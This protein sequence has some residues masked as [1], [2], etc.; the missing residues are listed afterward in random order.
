[1]SS[2]L[3]A[4]KRHAQFFYIAVSN[5]GRSYNNSPWSITDLEKLDL[6]WE[7]IE[8]AF[9]FLESQI[10]IH[11]DLAQLCNNY[12]SISGSYLLI[13]KHP[14][15][16]LNWLR[17]GLVAS[18]IIKRR[19]AENS[20]LGNIGNCYYYLGDFDNAM[21]NYEK[22]LQGYKEMQDTLGEART[23]SGIGTI[24]A[25]GG[26]FVRAIQYFEQSSFV[27]EKAGDGNLLAKSLL[28]IGGAHVDEGNPQS[29]LPILKRALELFVSQ[30]DAHGKIQ[31][32]NNIATANILLGDYHNA[33]EHLIVG[34]QEAN[35]L[36]A[37]LETAHLFGTLGVVFGKL[38][39]YEKAIAI[40]KESLNI[41]KEIGELHFIDVTLQNI[42]LLERLKI[43]S[44][45]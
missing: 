40:L 45:T 41:S 4:Q 25:A 39:E 14:M 21:A 38:H 33:V 12:V 10:H 24:Y 43:K 23:L 8:S 22:C 30:Q 26:D 17:A 35:R 29:A 34:L 28:N 15:V 19:E 27:A 7:N 13:R 11:T 37:K 16:Y 2:Q 9:K 36:G 3:T 1:M 5:L 44:K 20:H 18:Q 32:L 31:A 6:E 42:S